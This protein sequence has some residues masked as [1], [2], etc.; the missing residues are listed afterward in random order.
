[1]FLKK[2]FG[3]NEGFEGRGHLRR[4]VEGG[5]GGK[6]LKGKLARKL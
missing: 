1:M 4:E 2:D 6:L 3:W 5:D